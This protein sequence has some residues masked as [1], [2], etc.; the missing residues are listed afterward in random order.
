MTTTE[1]PARYTL[2][3]I[4]SGS[5]VCDHCGRTLARLFRVT[6]PDGTD[7]TVGR[8]CSAK[9]TGYKWNVALAER[10]ER[11]RIADEAAASKYGQLYTELHAAARA[12]AA[13]YETA[14]IAGDALGGLRDGHIDTAT[15]AA[16]LADARR[17]LPVGP[18]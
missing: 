9:L 15:A 1:A 17:L 5:G 3:G 10:I 8:T 18:R 14:G 13:R 12:T 7:L 2:R 6:S 4:T 16:W 11:F